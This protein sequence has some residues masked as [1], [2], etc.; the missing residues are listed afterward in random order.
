MTEPTPEY[1]IRK[2]KIAICIPAHDQS[3]TLFAYDFARLMLR[4]GSVLGDKIESVALYVLTSTY[5]H[6]ARQELAETALING[7]THILWLDSD[8][9]FPADCLERLLASGHDVVGCNYSNRG[10]PPDFVAMKTTSLG[11]DEASKLMTYPDST[12]LEEVEA[13]GFGCVL[14]SARVFAALEQPWFAME[15]AENGVN[16]GEDVYFFRK[17]AE[18][19]FQP[20]VDHDLSQE[21][22]HIGTIEYGMEHARA[23]QEA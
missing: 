9:R 20:Y 12:G 19:G 1:S 10:V 3:P 8:M 2:P 17:A 13:M 4:V 16:I 14:T 7:A 6:V 11:D 5:L 23:F 15:W 18:A 22:G 21:I